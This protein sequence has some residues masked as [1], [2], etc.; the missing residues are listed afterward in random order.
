MRV[1]RQH[2]ITGPTLGPNLAKLD[3]NSA[4]NWSNVADSRPHS[5]S[6]PECVPSFAR[7][8]QLCPPNFYQSPS[9]FDQI[10]VCSTG[11]APYRLAMPVAQSAC[12]TGTQDSRVVS[13]LYGRLLSWAPS[14]A[15]DD[16]PRANPLRPPRSC[17]AGAS[18]YIWGRAPLP[19]RV[20]AA[21]VAAISAPRDAVGR[22]C[23]A[24]PPWA[25][26]SLPPGTMRPVGGWSA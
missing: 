7:L 23:A 1:K 2:R 8:P 17:L 6:R 4:R 11:V 20:A 13:T 15:P 24:R 25:P 14:R 5:R 16:A 22:R 9:G 18:A 26:L 10:W 3:P 12:V 19:R 21:A